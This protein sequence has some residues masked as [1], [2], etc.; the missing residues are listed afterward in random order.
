MKIAYTCERATVIEIFVRVYSK[1]LLI[2][3]T[4]MLRSFFDSLYL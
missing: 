2:A 1:R 3:K 4:G